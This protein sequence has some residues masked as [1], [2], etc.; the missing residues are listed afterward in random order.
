MALIKCKSC[1]EQVSDRSERCPYCGAPVVAESTATTEPS[2]ETASTA[3]TA[4][5]TYSPYPDME[6]R[7]KFAFLTSKK[8]LIIGG[9]SLLVIA[10]LFGAWFVY[11]TF[12]GTS[13]A[14]V[15]PD[16]AL[17][18]VELDLKELG[19]SAGNAADGISE[20]LEDFVKDLDLDKENEQFLLDVL[21]NPLASGINFAKPIYM[22]LC[23]TEKE[24]AMVSGVVSDEDDFDKLI[25]FLEDGGADLDVSETSKGIKYVAYQRFVLMYNSDYFII[26]PYNQYAYVDGEI[27]E[28]DAD[29]V[30]ENAEELFDLDKSFADTPAYDHLDDVDGFLKMVITE[31]IYETDEFKRM[32]SGTGVSLS[33]EEKTSIV[34]ALNAEPGKLTCTMDVAK[35]SEEVEGLANGIK[36]TYLPYVSEKDIFTAA[37]NVNGAAIWKLVKGHVPSEILEQILEKMEK[38]AGFDLAGYVKSIN[39]DITFS[40]SNKLLENKMPE[41]ALY[42]KTTNSD[43]VA[44]AAKVADFKELSSSV[45][46]SPIYKYDYYDY[47]TYPEYDGYDYDYKEPKKTKVGVMTMGYKDKASYFMI[48]KDQPAVFK[49]ANSPIDKSLLVDK[50]MYARLNVQSILKMKLNGEKVGAELK[51]RC[52]RELDSD[53]GG[54]V[55]KSIEN[56]DYIEMEVVNDGKTMNLSAVMIDQ[57]KTPIEFVLN[58]L[59]DIY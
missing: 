16:D 10:L 2:V 6:K 36:G 25:E 8:A 23:G 7:S 58:E 35:A 51:K 47:P 29:D 24:D 19:S 22:A 18:V 56:I 38:E 48:S 50:L 57:D 39:G 52:K 11:K 14:D 5:T 12:F 32:M 1:G 45:W 41:M 44:F 34:F 15:I 43:V 49:K 13:G 54:A 46:E 40:V 30:V 3:T 20:K 17:V 37:I 28:I 33:D 26:K 21:D 27:E 31:E 59:M 4:S 55:Y 53:L 9:V 42:A